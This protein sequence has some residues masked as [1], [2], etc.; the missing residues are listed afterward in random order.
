MFTV[1]G[2]RGRGVVDL[3][4]WGLWILAVVL[5]SGFW[6]GGRE[7]TVTWLSNLAR[8]GWRLKLCFRDSSAARELE[9]FAVQTDIASPKT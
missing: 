7:F 4:D 1:G 6:G 5:A 8:C 9:G 2:F 3:C